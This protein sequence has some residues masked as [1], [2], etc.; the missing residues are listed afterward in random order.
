VKEGRISLEPLVSKVIALEEVADFLA[1]PK[2]PELLKVQIR[3]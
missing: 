3:I 1:K 2:D